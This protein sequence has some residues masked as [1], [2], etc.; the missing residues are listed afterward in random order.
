MRDRWEE[1]REERIRDRRKERRGLAHELRAYIII[2]K[3]IVITCMLL[4]GLHVINQLDAIMTQQAHIIKTQ[5]DAM[6]QLMWIRQDIDELKN[7]EAEIA[8]LSELNLT[9]D[10]RTL[11]ERI[12]AS[13]ARGEPIEGIM[14]VAQCI[15][16]R[17]QLWGMT[18]TEVCLA[19]GQFAAP[20]QGE[21]SPEVVQAVWAVFDEGMSVLEIPTTLGR[22]KL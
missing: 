15:R 1:I 4:M 9:E 7:N 8:D 21:I 2:A 16:D 19:P 6:D 3:I 18:V 10:E 17:S 11:V 14:A 22:R 20:Y 12:V 5:A 13:E